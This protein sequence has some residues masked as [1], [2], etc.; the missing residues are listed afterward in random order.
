MWKPKAHVIGRCYLRHNAVNGA[1]VDAGR[2]PFGAL[3]EHRT[4]G[5]GVGENQRPNR[6]TAL[7][8]VA[9]EIGALMRLA[10]TRGR[11]NDHERC[12]RAQRGVDGFVAHSLKSVIAGRSSA[13]LT[14]LQNGISTGWNVGHMPRLDNL[15]ASSRP[16]SKLL[17]QACA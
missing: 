16:P 3:G 6:A 10:A 8:E 5:V 1:S 15:L 2:C 12:V 11:L 14:A 17:N 7:R 13:S 4:R 9:R